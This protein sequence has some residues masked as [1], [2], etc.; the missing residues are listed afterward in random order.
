L[1]Q[2]LGPLPGE[3]SAGTPGRDHEIDGAIACGTADCEL[4]AGVRSKIAV[5][6]ESQHSIEVHGIRIRQSETDVALGCRRDVP[7]R[8]GDGIGRY[9][10]WGFAGAT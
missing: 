5:G 1:Q 8:T 7:A 4:N 9:G 3:V 6:G 2:N 10:G